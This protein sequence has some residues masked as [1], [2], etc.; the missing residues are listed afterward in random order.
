[1]EVPGSAADRGSWGSR[2]GFI[3]AAVGSAVGLGN[4]WRFS[5]VAAEGGGA[6]FVLLYM[7]F[8]MLI[9]VPVMTCELVVGRLTQ[10][11]PI[12]AI[13]R[14]GGANWSPLGWLFVVA[15]FGLLSYYS[16]IAGWTMRF[17]FDAF[18][19]AIPQDA[20]TYFNQVGTNIPAVVTHVLFMA[21]TIF[22]V[23]RGVKRGLERTALI[24]MPLLFLLLL[25]L[26]VWSATLSGGGAGYAYY[27]KPRL[28]E[29]FDTAI[30][31][32]AAGQAFFSL[33][34]G[35]GAIMT[36]ASYLKTKR[37]LGR[38]AITIAAT[39][40]GVAFVAGLVVFPIIFHFGLGEAI[41]LGGVLNTD[42]TVGTL[43]ITIPPA[44]QTVGSFGNL[45]VSAF[46]VMLFFAA[47]T[48]AISLLEVVVA[49][50]IDS[51]QWPR[52]GAAV[53]FGV[54]I[55]LAGIPSAIS[56]NFLAFADKLFGAFLLMLGGLFTAILVGYR[57]LPQ[58]EQEL[59]LGLQHAG[60]RRAWST[61]IRYFVPPVLLVV[62]LFGV[63]PLWDALRG[64]IG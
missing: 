63:K 33:S 20:A 58:A 6:A 4:M 53:T 52:A 62:L 21:V 46:F 2:L 47:L 7:L 18:R 13:R 43:F 16:V 17:A 1:M 60:V 59:A 5:Y 31:T 61:V 10:V 50:V 3:L 32:N 40:F 41:G 36:Y 28:G 26:A 44:L 9:G 34:L 27:L 24:L 45:I 55:T 19:G 54:L 29:L 64:L 49:S 38:E 23:A 30:I 25:G 35:M 56:L 37:N 51:W 14:I 22:I 12:K 39:D 42:N 15:G 57:A 48:S 11:S 8:V